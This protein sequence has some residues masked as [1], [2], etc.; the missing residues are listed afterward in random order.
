MS[1]GKAWQERLNNKEGLDNDKQSLVGENAAKL[2]GQ[3]MSTDGEYDDSKDDININSNINTNMDTIDAL[4]EEEEDPVVFRGF[5][6]EKDI[7]TVLNKLGEKGGKGI[8]SK[9][10]NEALRKVFRE[11]GWLE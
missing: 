9:I 6:L 1:K 3:N 10:V 8:K 7:V 4:F 5:Y 2:L 11:K